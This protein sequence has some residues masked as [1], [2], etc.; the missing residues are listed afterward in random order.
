MTPEREMQ[1]LPLDAHQLR[2]LKHTH[3]A[4][5][6]KSPIPHRYVMLLNPASHL[7]HNG[8]QI[9]PIQRQHLTPIWHCHLGCCLQSTTDPFMSEDRL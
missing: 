5:Q 7:I 2:R 4:Q 9:T 6:H 3:L 8:P 1:V